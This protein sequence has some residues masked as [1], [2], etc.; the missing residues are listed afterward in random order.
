[1]IFKPRWFSIEELVPEDL[2]LAYEKDILWLLFDTRLLVSADRLRDTYGAATIN[3]WKSGGSLSLR[4]WRPFDSPVGARFS[5]HKF[6]R[7]FDMNFERA[8]AEEIRFDMKSRPNRHCYELINCVEDKVT[9]LHI[10]T[11]NNVKQ[12]QEIFFINP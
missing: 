8:T 5:Q 7:A 1:M 6:G 11:R 3:N 12:Y 2:I 10:D 4:G 9:W